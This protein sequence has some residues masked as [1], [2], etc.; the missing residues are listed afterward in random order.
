MH[1]GANKEKKGKKGIAAKENKQ[2]KTAS[3][4][5]HPYC[6]NLRLSAT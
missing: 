2:K 4:A 1:L 3:P 5:N 6:N